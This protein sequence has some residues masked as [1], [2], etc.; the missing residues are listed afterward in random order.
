ML[1]ELH[2]SQL[3]SEY[4]R[5]TCILKISTRHPNAFVQQVDQGVHKMQS[6][7]KFNPVHAILII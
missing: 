5:N 1:K 2:I 3:L 6:E 4:F 7:E